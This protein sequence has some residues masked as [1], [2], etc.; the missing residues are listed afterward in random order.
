MCIRDS[1]R[2]RVDRGV[3]AENHEPGAGFVCGYTGGD[4]YRGFLFAGR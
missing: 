4:A 3:Y 1:D 2:D